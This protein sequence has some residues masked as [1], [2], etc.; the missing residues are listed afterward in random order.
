MQLF[1]TL[2]VVVLAVVGASAFEYERL[3]K[4]DSVLLVV[5]HQMG[6][7]QLVRDYTPEEYKN[8]IMAHASL[9]K[10]FNLPTILTTSAETGPNGLLPREIIE[11]HPDAPFIKRQGEVNAWDN[12][13]FRAAVRATGK[14]QV[15]LAGIVT[16]VCTTFL[17][18]SLVEEG[19]S[20]YANAEASGTLSAKIAADSNDRMRAAGVQVMSMFAIACDLMRD[21]RNTPGAM[22]L[23]PF[24]DQYMTAYGYLARSHAAAIGNGTIQPGESV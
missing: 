19:Y 22:E 20:V 2:C 14:K 15:I 13:D 6:L 16:D 11:M 3:N 7:F 4:N 5:D 17:A 9:G 21:W 23:L 1:R 18:L 8:N 12:A 24:Y 10:V